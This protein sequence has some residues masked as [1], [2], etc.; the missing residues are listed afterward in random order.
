MMEKKEEEEKHEKWDKDCRSRKEEGT[1][2]ATHTITVCFNINR[3][4][5]TSPSHYMITY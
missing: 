4:P 2:A 3:V 1:L 5:P